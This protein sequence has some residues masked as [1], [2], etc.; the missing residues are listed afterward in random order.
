MNGSVEILGDAVLEEDGEL[1]NTLS[2]HVDGLFTI[3]QR[4][5]LQGTIHF[6]RATMMGRWL[7]RAPSKSS[8]TDHRNCD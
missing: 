1:L 5:G 7:D 8:P 4:H 3:Y 2:L 6:L